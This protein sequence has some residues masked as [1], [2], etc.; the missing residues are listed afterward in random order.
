MAP[1]ATGIPGP[2]YSPDWVT[3]P[4]RTNANHRVV[5]EQ[6]A[7]QMSRAL[8]GLEAAVRPS[9]WTD[10]DAPTIIEVLPFMIVR[11]EPID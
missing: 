3:A 8:E 1:P 6:I 9:D 2:S 5:C 11:G 10:D 7:R 4:A